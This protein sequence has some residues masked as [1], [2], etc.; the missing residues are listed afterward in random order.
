MEAVL[1]GSHSLISERRERFL[2]MRKFIINDDTHSLFNNQRVDS[3][4]TGW[5]KDT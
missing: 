2:V 3:D 1:N 5:L 4:E